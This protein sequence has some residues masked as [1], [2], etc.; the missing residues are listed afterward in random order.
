M[1][2][3]DALTGRFMLSV[4]L[5]LLA[6]RVGGGLA[7][8]LRQPRVIGEVLVGLLL[9]PSLFGAF[10]P[11]LRGYLFP[12][13]ALPLVGAVANV[14]LVTYMFLIG[15]DLR[16][17]MTGGAAA[18]PM[19]RVVVTS[20][21]NFVVPFAIGV[22]GAEFISSP[23]AGTNDLAF[24]LFV[25][26]A[27][28]VSAVPVL[29][30]ILDERGLLDDPLG[31]LAISVAA[32]G[33]VAAWSVLGATTALVAGGSGS[34]FVWTLLIGGL[35][36]VG[37][38]ISGRTRRDRPVVSRISLGTGDWTV[39]LLVGVLAAT[40]AT[41]AGGIGVIFGS[42]LFGLAVGR[43]TSAP[44]AALVPLRGIANL[45][46]PLY[47]VETGVRADLGS[48]A[49]PRLL[50]AGLALIVLAVVVKMGAALA[51][52]A[53]TGLRPRDGLVVGVMLNARGL[54]ELV[55]LNV[56]LDAGI[57]SVQ[58]FTLFVVMALATTAFTGPA[59]DRLRVVGSG[60]ATERAAPGSTGS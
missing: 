50:G 20:L 17:P 36:I 23:P 1:L 52:S 45:L 4:A 7:Q 58:V 22:A 41:Q 54:T 25:G 57:I 47:F 26:V 60:P 34:V 48:L 19:R 49:D 53:L 35:A 56:G 40:F 5:L 9:G 28:A 10:L 51:A 8:R 12:E 39:G 55:V 21:L 11:D 38:L 24:H 59:L 46:V 27:L 30:R 6:A 33:D 18:V 44:E 3:G 31:R 14:A 32:N 37:A 16:R 43:L 13:P 2:T 15:V 29:A 42:F